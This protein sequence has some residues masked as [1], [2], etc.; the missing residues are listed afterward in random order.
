MRFCYF[1]ELFIKRRRVALSLSGL[2]HEPWPKLRPRLCARRRSLVLVLLFSGRRRCATAAAAARRRRPARRTSPRA[3]RS[4]APSFSFCFGCAGRRAGPWPRRPSV[5]AARLRRRLAPTVGQELCSA[6]ESC[7]A[8]AE[9]LVRLCRARRATA[10][11]PSWVL[12]VVYPYKNKPKRVRSQNELA[13]CKT[14]ANSQL[15]PQNGAHSCSRG[16]SRVLKE[17]SQHHSHGWRRHVNS[18]ALQ[19]PCQAVPRHPSSLARAQRRASR[20]GRTNTASVAAAQRRANTCRGT[21]HATSMAVTLHTQLGDLKVELRC[22]TAPRCSFNFLAWRRPARTTAR[23]S[24]G[25]CR[26]S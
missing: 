9:S 22:D 11:I 18:R 8:V 26:A 14:L 17:S 21:R 20:E 19:A 7:C 12:K 13:A 23:P 3:T 24:T 5:Q 16:A 10:G 15:E 1:L 25:S 4:R 6:S 2:I